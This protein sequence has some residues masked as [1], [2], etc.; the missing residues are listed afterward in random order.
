MFE[1]NLGNVY[2]PDFPSLISIMESKYVLSC[3][4]DHSYPRFI[5]LV[6]KVIR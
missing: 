5:Y 3:Q 6:S 4:D 1:T 2:L